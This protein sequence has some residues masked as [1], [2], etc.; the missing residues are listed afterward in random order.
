MRSADSVLSAALKRIVPSAAEQRALERAI[1]RVQ[2]AAA[3]A[4]K[5]KGLKPVLA[6]SFTRD[7]WMRHKR[8]FDLFICFP[9]SVPRERLEKEGLA[10]GKRIAKRLRG[11]AAV[12]YAE[13]PYTRLSFRGFS[14]DIVPCYAV[15]SAAAIKSAVDRTPFHNQWLAS[16]FSP[17]LAN[18][19]RLLKQFA[20]AAGLYGA[21]ARTQGLSGYL[22]ELLTVHAGGFVPLLQKARQWEPGTSIDIEEHHTD[23]RELG[24]RFRGHALIVVD[25][26]DPNRNVAAALSPEHFS[27]FVAQC[28][29]FLKKPSLGS[30]FPKE[31]K[32]SLP[33][34]RQQLAQRGTQWLGVAF[35]RPGVIDDTL[36][37]QLRKTAQRLAAILAEYGF[38]PM[39]AEAYADQERCVLLVELEVWEL[40][41]LR[42]ARGPVVFAHP[43]VQEFRKKYQ[44]VGRCFVEGDRWVAEV[45]RRWTSAA[46]KLAD[47][48]AAPTKVLEAKGLGSVVAPALA[49]RRRQKSWPPAGGSASVPASRGRQLLD[50]AGILKLAAQDQEFARFLQEFLERDI[51]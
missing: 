31:S 6:G 37:P 12:A 26:V 28:N 39:N 2:A 48:L 33:W 3:K 5:G 19:V 50:N 23:L 43:H 35:R 40:P 45:P 46:G 17:H 32:P 22:C 16:N 11:K 38:V 9:E 4:V 15:R 18:H 29:A 51:R 20:T 13:H 24:K 36:W 10:I 7:T 49:D 34:L 1:A 42:K 44:P 8:E 47:S 30:F 25:P 27:R 21:D 41:S 14:V